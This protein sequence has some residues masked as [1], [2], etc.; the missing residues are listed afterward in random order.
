VTGPEDLGEDW[1]S[2]PEPGWV[3]PELTEEFPGLQILSTVVAAGRGRSPDAL[4]E[5]LQELSN[6]FGGAQA[7]ML[8]Q[9]PI[10]WAYRV[11]F[12]HIG[13]DPDQTRTPIEQLGLDRMHDGS[14]KSRDRLD[15]ALT[16]GMAEV[17]VALTAFDADLIEGR[18]G[19]RLSAQKESFEGRTSPLPTGTIVIADEA[20]PLAILFGKHAEGHDVTKQTKRSALVAIGV[21]GVPDVALEEG[22]WVAASAIRA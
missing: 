16:I 12:R 18:L 7:I 22:L 15:D 4:K 2:A 19:L 10:P 20:R 17:G 5:L 11:F 13:L 8:R 3:E 6:R 1:E 21:K 9:R 14:F